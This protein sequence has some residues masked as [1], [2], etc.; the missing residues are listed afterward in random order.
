MNIRASMIP[1]Y[2]DCPRRAVAKSFGKKFVRAGYTFRQ[3]PP[4]VGAAAGT[5]VHASTAE[6]D[7][8]VWRGEKPNVDAAVDMAIAGFMEETSTGCTWDDTTPNANAAQHQIKRMTLAYTPRMPLTIN[9]EPAVEIGGEMGL[10]ANA[11]DGWFLTGHPDLIDAERFIRDKK[12]GSVVRPYHGQLG[13][14]SLLVRSNGICEP[15]GL[16]MDYIPR[17]PRTK[18]QKPPIITE[19]PVSACER[20]AMGIIQRIKAD[21][22]LFDE[23]GDLERAFSANQMSMMCTDKYCP[24]WGT[25]FCELSGK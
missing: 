8:A 14:Y 9:G 21:M 20:C 6:M 25:N 10:R 12:T 23:T 11:G 5:A 2:P 1:S 19:Y 15:A 3:L 13:G 24:A 16:G 17:T 18:G 4:S 22:K 7:R